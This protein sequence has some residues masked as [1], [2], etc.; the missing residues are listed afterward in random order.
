MTDIAV[1][2][3]ASVAELAELSAVASPLWWGVARHMRDEGLTWAARDESG[4]LLAVAG[5]FPMGDGKLE[6]WTCFAPA[7]R[8]RMGGIIAA[9]R[10]TLSGLPY[11][12]I[13]TI[14]TSREGAIIAR[15]LGFSFAMRLEQ[16]E[17]WTCRN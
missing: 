8:K 11:R 2:A 4:A 14:C 13:V 3:P 12:D 6:A 10:L 1:T 9:I 15:R 16:G 5:L 7:A 17:L